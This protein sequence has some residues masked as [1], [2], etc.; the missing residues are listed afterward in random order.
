LECNKL[1]RIEYCGFVLDSFQCSLCTTWKNLMDKADVAIVY[2]RTFYI[3]QINQRIFNTFP[4]ERCTIEL[5][6]AFDVST[7]SP[8]KIHTFQKAH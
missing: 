6:V 4:A 8:N 3:S 5:M 1:G 7:Y 2:G